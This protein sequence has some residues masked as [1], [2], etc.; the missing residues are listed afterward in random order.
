[1]EKVTVTLAKIDA[2]E[3]IN[4]FK[5]QN[6]E[7]FVSYLKEIWIVYFIFKFYRIW[8]REV[9]SILK[10]LTKSHSPSTMIYPESSQTDSSQYSTRTI[11]TTL[12]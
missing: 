5:I 1:M 10:E 12:T 2:E 11:I 8:R 7:I 3:L 4:E 9:K 6:V